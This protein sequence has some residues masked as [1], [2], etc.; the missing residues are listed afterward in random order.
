MVLLSRQGRGRMKVWSEQ[1]LPHTFRDR[2]RHGQVRKGEEEMQ[3]KRRGK[4]W[5]L[6]QVDELLVCLTIS[7]M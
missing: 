5:V 4:V 6:N 2:R 3:A 7:A 1:V